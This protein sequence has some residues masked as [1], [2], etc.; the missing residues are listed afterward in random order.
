M[1]T[2]IFYAAGT[3]LIVAAASCNNSGTTTPANSD[4]TIVTTTTTTTV[5]RKYAGS[6]VPQ[7]SVKYVDLRTQ[8]EVGARID[9]SLGAIV[10]DETSEPQDLIVEPRTHD[11]IYAVTGTI[12]NNFIIHDSTGTLRVDT[13]RLS[14]M[15]AEAR[16]SVET[17]GVGKVKYKEKANGKTKYKDDNVKVKEKNGVSITTQR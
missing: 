13:L 16:E 10:N 8:K 4:S 14:S 5:H 17:D 9:T 6:F 11:T 12:V 7:A 15:G 3:L 1:T 2:K